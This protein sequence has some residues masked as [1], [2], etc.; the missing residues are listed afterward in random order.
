MSANRVVTKETEWLHDAAA[1]GNT[2]RVKE[3]LAEKNADVNFHHRA[4]YGST[5]LIAAII[6]GHVETAEALLEGGADVSALKTPDA[7]SPLHEACFRKNPDMVRLLLRFKDQHADDL[8]HTKDKK[9]PNWNMIDAKNQFGNAPLHA[10]AMAGSVATVQ[11]MLDNG[12][13]VESINNQHSTPLHHACYCVSDNT[14]VVEALIHAK[15]DVNALDKNGSTPLSVAAR[16][17]QVGAIRL[18]LKAGADPAI[19][20]NVHRTPYTSAVLRGHAAAAEQLKGLA[21]EEEP[22]SPRSR[23]TSTASDTTVDQY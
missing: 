8:L 6:G 4:S 3:L 16:K 20:D 7:N 14:D 2:D 1:E 17:N 9:A 5:P 11:V 18:L 10:A 13:S 22:D 15:S 12:A 23:R 19:K 21:P